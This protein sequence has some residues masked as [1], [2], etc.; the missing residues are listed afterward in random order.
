MQPTIHR[1]DIVQ[2]DNENDYKKDKI[3]TIAVKKW[4]GIILESSKMCC[5]YSELY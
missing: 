4:S 5:E 2:E 3:K 1:E